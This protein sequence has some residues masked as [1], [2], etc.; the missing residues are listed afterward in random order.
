MRFG[1]MVDENQLTENA[2]PDN[3]AGNE[4]NGAEWSTYAFK[5]KAERFRMTVLGYYY[6][7]NGVKI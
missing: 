2:I 5:V 3:W 1:N 7:G 6:I 4:S